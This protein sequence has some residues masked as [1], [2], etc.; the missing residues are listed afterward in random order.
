V[1]ELKV[2]STVGMDLA[3]R[4]KNTAF[5]AIR[6][7]DGP[8]V[9]THLC[10]GKSVDNETGIDLHDKYLV[11][12]LVGLYSGFESAPITKAAID[13][14]FGWPDAFV[15]AVGDYA[16]AIRWRYGPD[17]TE[18]PE[19]V[20]SLRFRKT[21]LHVKETTG[22]NPLSVS[23]TLL[24]TVAMRCAAIL[25]E[26]E[27][28]DVAVSRDGHGMVAE[29]Y[30][31][32]AIRMWAQAT[33]AGLP[34]KMGSYKRGSGEKIRER[35]ALRVMLCRALTDPIGLQ[36]PD[37]LLVGCEEDDHCLDALV[38]ALLARAVELNQTMP[39]PDQLAEIVSREGWIHLPSH[40]IE[41]LVGQ[42]T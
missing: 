32:P 9:L 4:A 15:E 6:W 11:N 33:I 41:D 34:G 37:G 36:D 40:P 12:V 17:F 18:V 38:C 7:G 24:G 26:L 3:A 14:P 13:A 42:S 27:F 19:Q 16:T 25:S 30:P 5:C 22:R 20:N 21:D 10:R 8:P 28:K 23:S 35:S 31:D 2:T 39:P 1:S 29:V